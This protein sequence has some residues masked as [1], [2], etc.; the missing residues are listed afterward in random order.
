MGRKSLAMQL[1]ENEQENSKKVP[2][3][4]YIG[5]YEKA[6]KD[7]VTSKATSLIELVVLKI[8]KAKMPK[9]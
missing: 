2:L 1:I 9:E 5:E 8:V 4:L 3:L 7:A 6:L